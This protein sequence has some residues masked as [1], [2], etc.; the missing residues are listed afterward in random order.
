MNMA[1]GAMISDVSDLKQPKSSLPASRGRGCTGIGWDCA[2]ES[3][4]HRNTDVFDKFAVID[5]ETG[6][7]G[8]IFFSHRSGFC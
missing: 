1:A 3:G 4:A 6:D 8:Q 7:E 5:G 2:V